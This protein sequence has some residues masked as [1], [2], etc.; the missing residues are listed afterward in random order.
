MNQNT[1]T[2][3]IVGTVFS[4]SFLATPAYAATVYEDSFDQVEIPSLSTRPNEGT[5]W[6]KRFSTLRGVPTTAGITDGAI[7]ILT[8]EPRFGGVATPVFD[9]FDFFDRELTFTFEGFDLH[10]QGRSRPSSQWAKVGV[11]AGEGSI[12]TAYSHFII[13]YSATGQ[14]SVQVQEASPGSNFPVR[15]NVKDFRVPFFNF[16]ATELSKIQL[17]LDDTYFRI[18]FVFGNELDQLSFGGEHGLSRDNW[19]Y[20]T[21]GVGQAQEA[22]R[23]AQIILNNAIASGDQAA[24]DSAQA[25]YDTR[26]ATFDAKSLEADQLKGD[27]GLVI[28]GASNDASI[29]RNVRGLTD[30]GASVKVEA[31]RVETTDTLEVLRNP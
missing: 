31:V 25:N 1:L 29:L 2:K 27:T 7:N 21:I 18:L 10:P 15:K 30:I 3:W 4:A 13:A 16:D 22:V 19:L 6:V 12:W 8:E 17:V 28:M 11:T 14:F 9:D 20:D 26:V 24:I 23:I 5:D